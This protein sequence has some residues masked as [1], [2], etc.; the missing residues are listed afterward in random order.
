MEVEFGTL[1]PRRF[2]QVRDFLLRQG[3]QPPAEPPG[4]TVVLREGETV[5]ATGSLEGN[6]LSHIA[7]DPRNQ[8]E[9]LCAQVV[10]R[11]VA[12]AAGQ[13]IFH[14]LLCTKPENDALFGAAGFYPVARTAHMLLMEN[15]RE[16]AARFAASLPHPGAGEEA[17]AIVANCN[18]FTR[19]H[20]HLAEQAARACGFVYF[21]VLSEDRS[22]FST[23][24]RLAMARENLRDLPQVRVCETGPY[25]VSQATFPTYFLKD[26]ARAGEESM[27]LDL[28][29]FAQCFAKPLGIRRRFVGQEPLCPVTA[30]Y[31]HA[32]KTLLPPMGVEV[33]E[34]P[35]L[36]AEGGPI[37]ASRV[38][39]LVQ[40]GQWGA[41]TPLVTEGTARYLREEWKHGG[42]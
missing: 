9:G 26:R 11:L 6:V 7:V 30:A 42:K 28:T 37:S 2:S 32:M 34:I 39:A 33:V 41:L 25:M 1:S 13:G 18:P 19:G 36:A 23:R 15:V 27:E 22:F 5:T 38:R 20:R 16:G 10:S 17:G 31:N 24:D 8:G 21:F 40:A 14:L 4:F 35:R 12:H 3:L 29:V